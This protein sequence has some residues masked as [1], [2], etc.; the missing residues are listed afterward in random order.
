MKIVVINGQ[1]HKGS[2]VLI[3]SEKVKAYVLIMTI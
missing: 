3:V 1:N 2:T